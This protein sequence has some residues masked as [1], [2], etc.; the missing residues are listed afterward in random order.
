MPKVYFQRKGATSYKYCLVQFNA[1]RKNGIKH[2]V[3]KL[4][5]KQNQ[6]NSVNSAKD[7]GWDG[8]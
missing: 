6:G 8:G 3:F 7:K 1:W 5:M 4:E 2:I